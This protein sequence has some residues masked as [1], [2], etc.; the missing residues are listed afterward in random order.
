MVGRGV[1]GDDAGMLRAG[2]GHDRPGARWSVHPDNP[3]SYMSSGTSPRRGGPQEHPI[4]RRSAAPAG[5]EEPLPPTPSTQAP[6]PTATV[7]PLAILEAVNAARRSV[8]IQQPPQPIPLRRRVGRMVSHI[9]PLAAE[10]RRPPAWRLGASGGRRM[11]GIRSRTD[12]GLES[13][14]DALPMSY[15]HPRNTVNTVAFRDVRVETCRVSHPRRQP[16]VRRSS[17]PRFARSVPTGLPG[18]SVEVTWRALEAMDAQVPSYA[19]ERL[20]RLLMQDPAPDHVHREVSFWDKALQDQ[21]LPGEASGGWMLGRS[22]GL[23]PRLTTTRSPRFLV[24][25]G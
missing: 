15:L 24:L 13:A 12:R 9:V 21:S 1:C 10:G 6:E 19:G 14:P 7:W 3:L 2:L 11:P 8:A 22:R 20:A 5:A 25:S 17:P 18:Y 4:S 23:G 16:P